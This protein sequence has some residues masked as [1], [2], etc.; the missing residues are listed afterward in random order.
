VRSLL[1]VFY[2]HWLSSIFLGRSA[3]TVAEVSF[4]AQCAL[5]LERIAAQAGV[6]PATAAD[7]GL[8]WV[9]IVVDLI[10]P[11]LS[12]AQV[13]C[14]SSVV[15][16]NHL[17][18][19]FEEAIW[20]LTHAGI[21]LALA[22]LLPRLSGAGPVHTFAACGVVFA[23]VFVSFMVLVDVPMYLRRWRQ[24]AQVHG[25][26]V[27]GEDRPRYLSLFEGTRD[28]MVR[29]VP[30]PGWQHWR[31]E[32]AWLSGCKSATRHTTLELCGV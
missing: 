18:H 17:G 26:K 20:A 5:C 30:A 23:V 2:D 22:A 28:A 10:V 6:T 24:G 21:G 27:Q 29:R 31:E 3:A 13:C 4:A 14:W 11:L 1:Q 15:T 9:L 8:G 7:L 12:F 25:R 19:A 32:V 16:L